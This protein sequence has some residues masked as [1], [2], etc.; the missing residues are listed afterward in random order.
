MTLS[1]ST[2]SSNT[3][4]G[5]AGALMARGFVAAAIFNSTFSGNHATRKGG[6]IFGGTPLSLDNS[7]VAFNSSDADGGGVYFNDNTLLRSTIIARNTG[8]P[9]PDMMHSPTTWI[10]GNN[11][12]IGDPAGLPVF[13]DTL[14]GDPM[15][16]PLADNGGPTLTHALM[17]GSTAIDA[18]TDDLGFDNDQRGPG[19]HRVVGVAADIG[20][21]ETGNSISDE[22]FV[23]GFDP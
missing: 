7:T 9:H 1:Y 17:S 12:F 19:F 13:T 21:F 23:D 20:A 8:V 16:G 5:Y 18:G 10:S 2:L 15:L 14:T 22:I 11:D 4:A 6:A 3:S